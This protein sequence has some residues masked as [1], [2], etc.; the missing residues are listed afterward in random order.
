[1]SYERWKRWEEVM[2]E[3]ELREGVWGRYGGMLVGRV[4]GVLET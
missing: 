2:G 4:E 3:V 1:M